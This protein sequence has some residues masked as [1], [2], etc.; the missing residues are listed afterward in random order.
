[1]QIDDPGEPGSK[2]Y[3][4]EGD[5]TRRD[6]HRRGRGRSGRYQNGAEQGFDLSDAQAPLLI[7]VIGLVTLPDEGAR[8]AC[9]S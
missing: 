6:E 2:R 1:M 5:E 7:E 9:G 4:T 8:W 3:K